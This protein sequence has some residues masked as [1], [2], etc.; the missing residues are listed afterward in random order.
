ML[1]VAQTP[2]ES[3]SSV[4]DDCDCGYDLLDYFSCDFIGT[5]V[6]EN[7]YVLTFQYNGSITTITKTT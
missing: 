2:T 3:A 5:Q 7:A 6:S 4:S 1:Q